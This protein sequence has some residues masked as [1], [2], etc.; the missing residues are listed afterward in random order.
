MYSCTWS[1]CWPDKITVLVEGKGENGF[2]QRLPHLAASPFFLSM[3]LPSSQSPAP[4]AQIMSS[5][6]CTAL[7][8]P[9]LML[10]FSLLRLCPLPL[11]PRIPCCVV[12]VWTTSDLVQVS[13]WLSSYGTSDKCLFPLALF[14][15]CALG[16]PF[17]GLISQ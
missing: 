15:D 1:H 14:L 5:D 13:I 9:H 2:W 4:A 7:S 12:K 17:R 8:S 11:L 6:C 10:P 3:S 16:M